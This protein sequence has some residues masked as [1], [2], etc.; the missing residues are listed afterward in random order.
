MN[1]L[2]LPAVAVVLLLPLSTLAAQPAAIFVTSV[3]AVNGLSDP[4]KD[5]QDTVTDIRN[6]IRKD[7]KTLRLVDTRE[8]ALVVLVVLGREAPS[9]GMPS[10][11]FGLPMRDYVTRVKLIANGTES[12]LSSSKPGGAGS[13]G[14]WRKNAERVAKQV[15]AWVTTNRARLTAP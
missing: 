8:E 13:A 7:R 9:Q 6:T 15:E 10:G 4:N 2:L 1:V 5:N 12:E 14:A 3:G 11:L